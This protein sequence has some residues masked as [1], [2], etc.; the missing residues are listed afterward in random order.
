MRRP[1][2]EVFMRLPPHGKIIVHKLNEMD[3]NQAWLAAKCSCTRATVNEIILGKQNPSLNMA[4]RIS[5]ALNM[6][7]EEIFSD[8]IEKSRAELV[9]KN[10]HQ[11]DLN[12]IPPYG[13][14]ILSRLNQIGK[15]ETELSL[16]CNCTKEQI[17]KIISGKT[18]LRIS[19]AMEISHFLEISVDELLAIKDP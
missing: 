8:L 13:R 5:I 7:V 12:N 16:F 4:F 11:Y 1:A 9:V 3:R 19:K 18:K 2:M 6:S 17:Q 14:K 10:L 15:T